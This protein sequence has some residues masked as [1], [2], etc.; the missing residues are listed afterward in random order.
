MIVE[1]IFNLKVTS[2][3]CVI[4]AHQ[5]RHIILILDW[6][7]PSLDL[8]A[9]MKCEATFDFYVDPIGIA[10]DGSLLGINHI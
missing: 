9:S 3:G 8:N 2:K 6:F 7:W 5:V 10:E 1:V 4:L